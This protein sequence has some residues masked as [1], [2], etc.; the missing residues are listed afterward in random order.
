MARIIPLLG[1]DGA[2]TLIARYRTGDIID[3]LA[4]DDTI[5]GSAGNDRLHGGDGNDIIRPGLGHDFVDGGLGIDI[6]DYSDITG[7]RGIRLDLRITSSQNT[8]AA[9]N[10]TIR[11][12]ENVIGTANNDTITGSAVANQLFGGDGNDTLSGLGG[13]DYVSGGTGSDTLYGGDGDDYLTPSTIADTGGDRVYG[14]NG[15]D[16][17][18]G[19]AGNDYLDGGND[20]DGLYAWLG[21]DTLI[22][23]AGNDRL[24]GSF[25]ADRLTGGTGADRFIFSSLGESTVAAADTIT[26]FNGAEDIIQLTALSFSFPAFIGA[27]AFSATGAAQIRVTTSL[28]VQF[29]EVDADGNGTADMAI[30]VIGTALAADDFVYSPFGI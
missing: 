28:G 27:A 7:T 15:S 20:N 1:T 13:N 18:W 24:D 23:G 26:D 11:N 17:V 10:D 5:T 16:Q 6:V 14:G 22:G 30:N 9:G 2:D 19:G 21:N 29:V 3:G 8:G 25:G 4:G 12:V